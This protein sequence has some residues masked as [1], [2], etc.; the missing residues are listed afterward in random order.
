MLKKRFSL[1]VAVL[2]LCGMFNLAYSEHTK[3]ED[4]VR[5]LCLNIG[6]ADCMLL[7][8]GEK[9]FL[10]DAG[11]E[12]TWPALE[13]ALTQYKIDRLNGV[14]LTHCHQD[15]QGGL[16]SLA[17]S[18]I[19]VDAWYAS[20]IF[21][22]IMETDHP[23]VLAAG[24]RGQEVCWLEAG[25]T[26]PV[27]REAAFTVLG[28][29]S[30][31]EEN[32]NNNSLVMRFSSPQG[33]ILFSGDMK[34][35]EEY[36]LL[37]A[38]MLSPCTLLKAGHHGDSGAT[39]KAFLRAVSPQAAIILTSSQEEPD[40]PASSVITRLLK[41]GCSVYVSQDFHDA[42]LITLKNNLVASVDDVTWQGV[43]ERYQGLKLHIDLANDTLTIENTGGV[44]LRLDGY[45][46]YSTKGKDLFSLPDGIV[47][48]AGEIMSIGSKATPGKTDLKWNLKRVWHQSKT[49]TA[50]LYDAYGRPVACTNNGIAE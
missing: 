11:Y 10:I 41:A 27:S 29:L 25:N 19:Q 32:E 45:R 47:L 5:L 48:N 37:D 7:F 40:T 6:K 17:R 34:E 20:S 35:D 49:D 9:T 16:L 36:E 43:P 23:A 2:L 28:P 24:L 44:S 3:D 46:L 1:L 21:H 4:A 22:N 14:F 39:G 33:S 8:F 15:H 13:T 42:M 12:Q 38:G 31:N 18:N 26:V 50:I 30:V